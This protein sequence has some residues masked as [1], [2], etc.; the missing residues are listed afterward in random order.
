MWSALVVV[1]KGIGSSL[2]FL[3]LFPV[4]LVSISIA[5][6]FGQNVPPVYDLHFIGDG[7]PTAINN[8]GTV[9]GRRTVGSNYVPLVSLNGQPWM[10]LPVPQGSTSTFPTDIND[11][12][13]IVGV[14]YTN[15]LPVA[16]RWIRGPSGFSVQVLPRIYND[17][18]SYATAINDYG[19]IT[20]TRNYIGYLPSG[21]GWV[22]SDSGGFIDLT[23]FGFWVPPSDINNSGIIVGSQERLDLSTGQID[24]TGQ[25]PANYNPVA[26]HK[27]NAIGQIAGSA[28]L[29]ST[30]LVRITVFRRELNGEWS[31]IAG[32]TRYTAVHSINSR[33]DIGYSE[34]GAGIFFDG[35]GTYGVNNL[36]SPDVSA[37]G[38]SITGG[39]WVN[40]LRI[41]AAVGA[42][43]ISQQEGAV[44]LRPVG[45]LPPPTAPIDLIGIPRPASQSQPYN[46]IDL[47]WTN[48][49]PLT[50]GWELQRSVAG[51]NEWENLQLIPPGTAPHH[52]DTTVGVNITYNYRVRAVGTGGFSAWSNVVTV[53][54]PATPPDTTPPV[55]SLLEPAN[56]ATVSGIVAVRSTSTDNVGVIYQE[57]SFWNQFIGQRVIIASADRGGDLAGNWDTRQLTPATYRLRAYAYDLMGNWSEVF[58]DVVVT[59]SINP[60]LRV[61][62]ITLSGAG[63]GGSITVTGNVK[64]VDNAGS[65][66]NQATVTATWFTPAGVRLRQTAQTDSF[67]NAVFSTTSTAGKY[68]LM[69]TDVRKTGYNFNPAGSQL[70]ATSAFQ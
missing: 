68:R 26:S 55:V 46:S 64:V 31:S 38:W 45:S 35:L 2:S 43:S 24:V 18:I 19:Q 16:V 61:S 70:I 66:V 65:P 62:D 48:T 51:S 34:I 37:A 58:A 39:T 40:D 22:Y 54:S 15:W 41:I 50:N 23:S 10:E 14:S 44:L 52:S 42:N 36:L 20:G 9:I 33:G 21:A 28:S 57:L 4:L 60:T 53:T 27:I 17:P 1:K 47:S 29:R 56:G 30:S 7:T 49:S 12:D 67:G 69:I 8:S 32:S 13:V 25:G 3:A 63:S 5:E 6:A 11:S 59:A